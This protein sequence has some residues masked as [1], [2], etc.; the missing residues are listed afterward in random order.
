MEYKNY[1]FIAKSLDGYIADKNGGLGWLEMVP[2]PEQK[3][4]GFVKF[5]T[6]VDAIIMG[7]T[8]FE[9]VC[10]FGGD[11]P[12]DKPVFVLSS[13]LKSVPEKF[14]DKAEV[15]NGSLTEVLE[16]I[17]KKGYSQLYIEG[18][19]TIQSF[20]K[21][22]LIDEM[23]ISTIPI[24]LGGGIPLFGDLPH[25]MEFEHVVSKVFLSAITQDTYKRRR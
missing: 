23:I 5:L 2:N 20:L 21:E 1:I 8:T 25:E 14:Q 4:L 24:L 16:S 6:K 13:T 7:R 18:G 15:V 9:V 17:H 12:Y 11:W 22:D 10:G 3:D 19:A